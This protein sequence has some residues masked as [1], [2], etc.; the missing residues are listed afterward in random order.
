MSTDNNTT[1]S[2]SADALD[3]T[4]PARYIWAG[5][6][7]VLSLILLCT[8]G[9][10][11]L[12]QGLRGRNNVPPTPAPGSDASIAADGIVAPGSVFSVRGSGFLPN[13]TVEIFL[14]PSLT[15][16]FAEYTLLGTA[17]A[18]PDGAFVAEN[19]IA[20][21][22]P[23][24]YYLIARGSASGFSEFTPITIEGTA[25]LIPTVT[26][27]VPVLPTVLPG[28]PTPSGPLP[29]LAIVGV[30]IQ[31]EVIGPCSLAPGQLGV[32]VDIQNIGTAAAGPFAVQ[33]NNQ[34]QMVNQVL[35]PGQ[36]VSLWFPGFSTGNNVVIV[37]PA[38]AIVESN[39]DNNQFIGS[40][41]VPTLLP[42]CT[43]TPGAPIIVTPT[44]NPD[45]T[46]AWFV[47]YFNNQDLIPPVVFEQNRPGPFLNVNWGGNSPGS[48]VPRNGWSAR[49]SSNQNFPTTDNYL[50][51]LTVD[52]GARVFVNDTMIIN[53]W[54]SGGLRTVTANL[55]LSAGLYSVRVEYYKSGAAARVALNWKVNY[56]GWEGRYYNSPNLDG[57]IILKRDDA[58]EPP[59]PPGFLNSALFGLPPPGVN[60]FNFSADWRRRVTF[61]LAGTYVFTATVDDGARLLID[62]AIVAG[63][64][65]FTAGPKVLTGVRTLSAGVHFM[66][67]QY[68][69]YTGPATIAVTWA[70]PPAPPTATPIAP[71]PITV[72]VPTATP[73]LPVPPPVT[74]TDTPTIVV[75]VI[76]ITDTPTPTLV[77]TL[78]P[79]PPPMTPTPTWT[80]PAPPPPVTPTETSTPPPPTVIVI[81][82]TP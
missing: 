4:P 40:L 17:T 15:A 81:V 27:G 7:T 63:V 60:P 53:Q 58:V 59:D 77:P 5:I 33:V 44:P 32:R 64:D 3:T 18:G 55:G 42:P 24:Q 35:A 39:R 8:I 76:V 12:G 68:V 48:G 45:V 46:G 79:P 56:A 43:P 47:Q 23:G 31:P 19:L 9:I 75:T 26:P 37:D 20:P 78:P 62:G 51:T 30:S 22:L 21:S 29:D 11:L 13:E 72:I 65:D 16:A 38:G 61:P 10:V 73:T 74:P 80:L 49:F 54:F 67:I 28:L 82:P 71:P 52:G 1:S 14:A 69:N 6:V 36:L 34:Q 70:L 41:P 25:P 2:P 66:Q 50:F 57:P